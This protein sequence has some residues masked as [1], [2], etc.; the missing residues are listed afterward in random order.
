MKGAIYSLIVLCFLISPANAQPVL[1]G[2]WKLARLTA[3][4]NN[5][6]TLGEAKI[7]EYN[8][9]TD[10]PALQCSLANFTRIVFTPQTYL[11]QDYHIQPRC[12]PKNVSLWKVIK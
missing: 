10:D 8:Y 7:A 6:T 11:E 9:M 5:L 4:D 3:D 12:G 2:T 1:D